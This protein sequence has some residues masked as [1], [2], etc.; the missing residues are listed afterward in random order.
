MVGTVLAL[1]LQVHSRGDALPS[2]GLHSRE[3]RDKLAKTEQVL[4]CTQGKALKRQYLILHW[5]DEEK[6]AI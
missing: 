4:K 1:G 2:L 3:K 6:L 5:K